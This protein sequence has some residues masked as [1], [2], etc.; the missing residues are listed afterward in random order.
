LRFVEESLDTGIILNTGELV[1]ILAIS[2][3]ILSIYLNLYKIERYDNL[4]SI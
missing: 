2:V 3:L 1:R 4:I